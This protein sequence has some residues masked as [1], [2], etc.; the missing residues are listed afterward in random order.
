MI[1]REKITELLNLPA[2]ERREL[3]QMLQD[4]LAKDSTDLIAPEM[5]G[6]SA[7]ARWLLA[8][9]GR[10][11]GAAQDTAERA[12]EILRQELGKNRY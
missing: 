12:D 4:S 8:R 9:A 2:T 11:T 1:K 5:N 3:I 10:Y 6:T 7:G